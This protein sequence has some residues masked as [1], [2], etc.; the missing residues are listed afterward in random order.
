MSDDLGE[1]T[2]VQSREFLIVMSILDVLMIDIHVEVTA[3]GVFDT[4]EVRHVITQFVK[5]VEDDILP[6][7]QSFI[8]VESVDVH[9]DDSVKSVGFETL[10]R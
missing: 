1:K 9:E 5:S 6:T 10:S 7:F 8:L 4:Q 2:G 3:W